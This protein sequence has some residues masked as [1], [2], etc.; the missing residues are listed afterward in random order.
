MIPSGGLTRADEAV[1]LEPE[2]G[3]DRPVTRSR[4]GAARAFKL[5]RG[6][7]FAPGLG[8]ARGL[9]WA[10]GVRLVRG[11]TWVCGF[12]LACGVGL[13]PGLRRAR[14]FRTVHWAVP[15]RR[16]P[17]ALD[18]GLP[19]TPLTR[20][21][22]LDLVSLDSAHGH[23]CAHGR[24]SVHGH[25][26]AHG[27]RSVH[28]H[29]CAHGRRSVHGHGC[30]H[31]RRSVHGHGCAR[32][33]R[34]ACGHRSRDRGSGTVWTAAVMSLLIAVATAF[35][36]VGAARVAR[37]RAQAGADLSA[38]AAARLA[39]AQPDDACQAASRIAVANGGRLA[40]C[41]VDQYVVDVDV[42]VQVTLPVI[43]SR[44]V[45]GHARAGPAQIGPR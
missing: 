44:A 15:A 32:G 33:H 4:A 6:V 2:T 25:G 41:A 22:L 9:K 42:S 28:G 35:A 11:F 18:K 31:G 45:L 7:G 8:L 23:G 29:G 24:R 1:A 40:R 39:I 19:I 37:H 5:A 20:I 27:R 36:T 17:L 34:S 43:G 13:V 30:A 38:L 21:E 16:V 26:C 14:G 3:T 10:H 12:R